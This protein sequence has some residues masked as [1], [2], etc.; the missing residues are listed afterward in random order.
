MN[1]IVA[2]CK[3]ARGQTPFSLNPDQEVG[4]R[5]LQ[6]KRNISRGEA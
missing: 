1:R 2:S 5:G 6:I 4:W 3:A